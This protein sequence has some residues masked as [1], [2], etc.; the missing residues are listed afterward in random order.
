MLQGTVS[1]CVIDVMTGKPL[2]SL[3]FAGIPAALEYLSGAIVMCSSCGRAFDNS[4]VRKIVN[5]GTGWEIAFPH[6][7]YHA[8]SKAK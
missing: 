6:E 8:S 1:F 3:R 5:R 4:S 7:C 2:S